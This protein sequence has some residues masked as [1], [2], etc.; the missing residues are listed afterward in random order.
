MRFVDRSNVNGTDDYRQAGVTHLYLK[1]TEGVGFVDATYAA[2]H[3]QANAE[4][5]AHIGA[6][7]FADLAD[8][9][10]EAD[11]FLSVIGKPKAGALR[12]CLDM[13]RGTVVSDVPWAESWVTAVYDKLGY[14]PAIYGSTSLL[15]PMRQRSH[16]LR[17]CPWWR[18]EYGPNDGL[19]HPLTG[20]G[21]GASA[22][23]YTSVA[24]FPGISG[25]TD[26]SV[27]LLPRELHAS[28]LVPGRWVHIKTG[29]GSTYKLTG[30]LLDRRAARRVRLLLR[31]GHNDLSVTKGES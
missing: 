12:P 22:H 5:V 19:V 6:Y 20:G 25:A 15:Y 4:G 26:A 29:G 18:S 11:H 9:K 28:L 27:L 16:L 21:L 14:L 24:H 2:R 23:Q 7:H 1:A 8:P 3:R 30:R 13:E 17:L 31:S 10:A